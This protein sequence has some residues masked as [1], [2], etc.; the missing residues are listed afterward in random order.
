VSKNAELVAPYRT[1]TRALI[2]FEDYMSKQE[3]E[4]F[5]KDAL[6]TYRGE[7]GSHYGE[8]AD[9]LVDI[10]IRA[11]GLTRPPD[12][13]HLGKW[14]ND[15]LRSMQWMEEEDRER[16]MEQGYDPDDIQEQELP[17]AIQRMTI[18]MITKRFGG[19]A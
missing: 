10:V 19:T 11:T 18:Q 17:L 6:W 8:Y 5:W 16:N 1:E 14:I 4:E 12:E 7:S 13:S 3:L 9:D 15:I 2:E